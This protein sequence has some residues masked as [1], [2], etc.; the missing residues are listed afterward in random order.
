MKE[1]KLYP[2]GTVQQTEDFAIRQKVK[3]IVGE[4]V[5]DI[6]KEETINAFKKLGYEEKDSYMFVVAAG[7]KDNKEKEIGKGT[8]E[9]KL[10]VT[11]SIPKMLNMGATKP[12]SYMQ[13]VTTFGG[14]KIISEIYME[15]KDKNVYIDYKNTEAASLNTSSD[16]NK[17]GVIS[18]IDNEKSFRKDFKNFF[19]PIAE[20]EVEYLIGTKIG[21]DDK[22]E[23]NMND[24]IVKENKYSMKL[25]DLFSSSFE[26]AESKINRVVNES[27]DE[28]RFPSFVNQHT[29]FAV[30]SKNSKIVSDILFSIGASFRT[31][32]TGNYTYYE[33]ESVADLGFAA[34]EVSKEVPLMYSTY[35]EKESDLNEMRLKEG[36][37]D[38]T[39]GAGTPATTSGKPTDSELIIG[40]DEKL[41]EENIDE[42]TTSGAGIGGP[43]EPSSFKYAAPGWSRD[44][45][46]PNLKANKYYTQV[47]MN[48]SVQ[49]TIYGSMRTKRPKL[50]R[51]SNGD[52]LF[53]SGDPYIE[54]VEMEPGWLNVP[55]GMNKPYVMGMHGVEVNSKKELS[56]TGH[57]NLN[58]LKETG[59]W[60][61]NDSEM[62]DWLESLRQ[63]VE[64]IE[65]AFPEKVK[66]NSIRG[67]DKYQG[68]YAIVKIGDGNHKIW[69]AENY[70]YLWIEDFP[71]DNTSDKDN[72]A[73]FMG[74]SENIIDMLKGHF[75]ELNE[76][77][78][79]S[80]IKRKFA[81]LSE[82]EEKGINKRYIITEKLSSEEQKNRWKK[83][84]EC[85]CF[86]GIKDDDN[87]VDRSEYEVS[88]NK[89]F[90]ANNPPLESDL[91]DTQFSGEKEG[92]IDVPKAK[93]SM[94]V[95]R[96]FESDVNKN[97]MYILDHFTKKMVLN[98]LF[99]PE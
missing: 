84:Y 24:S 56:K 65:N 98:P 78:K 7:G 15:I 85:D 68:P 21:N 59:E 30:S 3:K 4:N 27:L 14:K 95:F 46:T 47:K 1:D 6:I 58:L 90:E 26:D 80:L 72:N 82:N 32:S 54:K 9:G 55:K 94:V 16:L 35:M 28:M 57:G 63:E 92:Y 88:A 81:T 93:G 99:K 60:D 69:T 23:K 29:S 43:T 40:A 76:N 70:P 66:L 12:V 33:F 19:Q 50:T 8:A 45:K 89:E 91:C 41:E 87:S 36:K 73:G 83:L 39:K 67:F 96:L 20:S 71:I 25:T 31:A 37:T 77:S 10:V 61:E 38:K 97:K 52:Y 74:T 44:G 17:S 5:E 86:C 64:K 49:G 51:Q 13:K 22:I 34:E 62:Q 48:E 2:E 79:L 53:E 42:T 11:V 18:G 75:G